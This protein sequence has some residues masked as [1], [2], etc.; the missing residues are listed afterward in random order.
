MAERRFTVWGAGG[1]GRVVAE[2]LRAEFGEVALRYV[3]RDSSRIGEVCEPGG[4][5][6]E[7]S[8]EEFFEEVARGASDPVVLAVGN[9]GARLAMAQRLADAGVELPTLVH[10]SAVVSDYAIVGVG[11][12]IVTG[13]IVH[14]GCKIGAAVIVNTRASIDHDCV[15]GDGVHISPGATLAGTVTV[16]DR[17]WVGT[18]ASVIPGVTI[19]SDAIVGAGAVVIRDVPDGATV[20]G[21]PARPIERS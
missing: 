17:S 12:H 4:G 19:G 9:N 8:E 5:R 10:P 11:T 1:H 15:L 21:C 20:V 3:D 16:G 7:L 14:P 2:L 13:A 6:V 18:G